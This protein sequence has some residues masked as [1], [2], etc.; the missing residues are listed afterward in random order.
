VHCECCWASAATLQLQPSS[1]RRFRMHMV[2]IHKHESC[3]PFLL[4]AR[5][6]I[7]SCAAR[8]NRRLCRNAN[9]TRNAT[10]ACQR[11][12]SDHPMLKMDFEPMAS[13]ACSASHVAFRV[14]RALW[15]GV[16][17]GCRGTSGRGPEPHP[18]IELRTASG[19]P[20]GSRRVPP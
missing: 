12:L 5:V 2:S 15:K 3:R 10:T 14:P 17:R 1:P 16:H 6:L 19:A 20:R 11:T 9:V 13:G 18:N 8:N 7:L 4:S